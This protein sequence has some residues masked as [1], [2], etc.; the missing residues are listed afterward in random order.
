MLKSG[1]TEASRISQMIKEL[2]FSN[3]NQFAID[4]RKRG[5]TIAQASISR[6][7]NGKN[8]PKVD[9]YDFVEREYGYSGKWLRSGE[10][11][12]KTE[13]SEVK[14]DTPIYGK[15]YKAPIYGNIYCGKP[16]SQ[17]N[18][19]EVKKYVSNDLHDKTAFGLIARGDSMR[20]YINPFDI[21][22]CVDAPH[23]IKNRT[24]VVVVFNS[25]PETIEANAKLIKWDKK[26]KEIMLYSVNTNFEPETFKE[27]DILKIYKVVEIRRKVK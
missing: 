1:E 23:L 8:K 14:E 25:G 21:L 5:S 27:S 19:E 6:F 20:P 3:P 15:S 18:T 26:R 11:E 10:G 12:I 9:F 2:G 4:L 22:I 13:S 17:W 24:A 7:V 16:V